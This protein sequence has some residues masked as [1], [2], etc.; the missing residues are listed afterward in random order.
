MTVART[1]ATMGVHV[2]TW[3]MTFTVTAKMGGKGKPATR[4]SVAAQVSCPSV[5]EGN[6]PAERDSRQGL[7][8]S[9]DSQCDEATCNNGGTCYDE[10][11]TFKCMCPGGWEGTTCNIGN[12]LPLGGICCVS[13]VLCHQGLR[14][15]P[16]VWFCP[17]RPPWILWKRGGPN[18]LLFYS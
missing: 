9:G 1:L 8:S 11:D 12:L 17:F 3:S 15:F 2:E 14:S 4:V 16:W 5:K 10:V 6:C 7:L 13:E 18:L